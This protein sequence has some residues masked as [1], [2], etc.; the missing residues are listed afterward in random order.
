MAAPVYSYRFCQ[1]HAGASSSYTVPVG[2]RA[3]VRDITAFNASAVA[4]ENAQVVIVGL[5][6]TIWQALV[7]P[8]SF[9]GISFRVVIDE[10][11][12]ISTD[13]GTDVDMTVSG[14]LL[15]LP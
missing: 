6:I 11:E 10:G 13:P 2:F 5:A 1:G 14:Y 7:A 4:P 9:S 8:S 12:T 3:V 15:S